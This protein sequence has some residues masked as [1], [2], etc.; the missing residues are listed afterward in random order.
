MRHR[1]DVSV[2]IDFRHLAG[3]SIGFSRLTVNGRLVLQPILFHVFDFAFGETVCPE[4]VARESGAEAAADV[5]WFASGVFIK[6]V[7]T[8]CAA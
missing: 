5:L 1:I 3:L 7:H 8:V 2:P 4:K 6:V